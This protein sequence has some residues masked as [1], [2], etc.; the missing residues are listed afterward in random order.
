MLDNSSTMLP[1]SLSRWERENGS[2][3]LCASSDQH[4]RA[5]LN[6]VCCRADFY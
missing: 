5:K 6:S 3:R 4:K 1:L 2:P